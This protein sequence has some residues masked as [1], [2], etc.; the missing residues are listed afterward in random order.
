[1]TN[2]DKFRNYLEMGDEK[3]DM[4]GAY[5]ELVYGGTPMKLSHFLLNEAA[6]AGKRRSFSGKI[7]TKSEHILRIA[8]I[9]ELCG[10]G[11]Q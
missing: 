5:G 9:Q 11:G 4:D 2:A 8:K 6:R 3:L 10:G 1:M 7:M